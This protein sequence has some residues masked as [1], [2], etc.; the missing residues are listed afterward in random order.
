MTKIQKI[1]KD[2]YEFINEDNGCSFKCDTNIGMRKQA[3]I[4]KS[5]EERNK[6]MEQHI[7]NTFWRVDN[8][9]QSVNIDEF[10]QYLKSVKSCKEVQIPTG[11]MIFSEDKY[12]AKYKSIMDK[13]AQLIKQ[14]NNI[15]NNVNMSVP[16][17]AKALMPIRNELNELNSVVLSK[18]AKEFEEVEHIT[19]KIKPIEAFETYLKLKE[20]RDAED[21]KAKQE[22]IDKAIEKEASALKIVDDDDFMFL[23]RFYKWVGEGLFESIN[24]HSP[25]GVGQTWQDIVREAVLYESKEAYLNRPRSVKYDAPILSFTKEEAQ[26]VLYLNNLRKEFSSKQTEKRLQEEAK[27][28]QDEVESLMKSCQS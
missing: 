7:R 9:L 26:S 20:R 28:L 23:K 13:K 18:D 22:A 8:D 17:R 24:V 6:D 4:N 25:F 10:K 12:N 3:Q 16:D 21:A 19:V 14:F 15:A 27:K 2:M 11:R 1:S 5:V